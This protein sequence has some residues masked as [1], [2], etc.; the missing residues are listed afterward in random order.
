MIISKAICF[1][2]HGIMSSIRHLTFWTL[3]PCAASPTPEPPDWYPILLALLLFITLTILGRLVSSIP[4]H[5]SP[6][7]CGRSVWSASAW[8]GS[9]SVRWSCR[10]PRL[11][12]RPLRPPPPTHL[13]SRAPTRPPPAACCPAAWA[14]D[15]GGPPPAHRGCWD[16]PEKRQKKRERG[17][18]DGWAWLCTVDMGTKL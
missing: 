10:L 15:P 1:L 2:T 12:L 17:G 13:P 7:L 4:V 3:N 8:P 16:L 18:G 9:L 14:E 6:A 11:Q 5:I